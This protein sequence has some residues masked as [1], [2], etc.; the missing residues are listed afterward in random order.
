MRSSAFA[1]ALVAALIA[2][3]CATPRHGAPVPAAPQG[4]SYYGSQY[5]VVQ[6][7]D[8]VRAQSQTSGGGALVGGAV[9]GLV[10]RQLEH[11]RNR[12]LATGVGVV[13]GAIIGNEIEKNSR[14]ARDIYRVTVQ[15]RG[16]GLRSFDY[17]S[18]NDDLRV[19][20]R[21]RIENNQLYRW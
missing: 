1:A 4:G 10:G 2:T 11:G 19:G 3:G 20:D 16:G 14:G 12:D 18:L 17:A 15:L 6:S 13:A 5:G 21:V 9:G 7:I 8:T